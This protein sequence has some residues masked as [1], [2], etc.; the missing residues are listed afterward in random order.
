MLNNKKG[1]GLPITAIILII[2]GIVVLAVLII[3]FTQGWGTLKGWFAGGGTERY[4]SE[5]AVACSTQNLGGWC[6]PKYTLEGG[7]DKRNCAYLVTA[8]KIVGCNDPLLTCAA[9]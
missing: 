6:D 4:V 9:A 1:Q 3:G 8:K 2:L 5:C 7:V